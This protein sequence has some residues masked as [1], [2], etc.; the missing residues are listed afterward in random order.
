MFTQWSKDYCESGV[1]NWLGTKMAA[2]CADVQ[3]TLLHTFGNLTLTG[4]NAELGTSRLTKNASSY[5]QAKLTSTGGSAISR[6][7]MNIRLKPDPRCLRKQQQDYGWDQNRSYSSAHQA[8]HEQW[9]AIPETKTVRVVSVKT[10]ASPGCS[11][12]TPSGPH[13]QSRADQRATPPS[14]ILKT[15]RQ[16]TNGVIRPALE[17]RL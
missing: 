17:A 13:H 10:I 1:V 2:G 3:G 9:H 12:L 5:R 7:G 4:Y 8:I 14:D 11:P 6:S 16:L 15:K